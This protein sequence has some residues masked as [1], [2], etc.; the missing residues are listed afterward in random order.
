[1]EWKIKKRHSLKKSEVK[2]LKEYIKE[3]LGEDLVIDGEYEK[4]ILSNRWEIILVDKLPSFLVLEDMIVPSLKIV[5]KRNIKD[6]RNYV[7]VDM[8][9]VPYIA[10]G[11]DVMAPGI[12]EIGDFERDNFVF[13]GDEKNGKILSIGISLVNSKELS[14]KKEGKVIKTLHYVGDKFWNFEV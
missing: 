13:V 10:N 4:C 1:M 2:K 5:M 9:A 12:V 11:A 6:F 3:K 8:G 7:V 14:E